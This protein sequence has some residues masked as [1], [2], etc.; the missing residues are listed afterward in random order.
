MVI[1]MLGILKAG[2]AYLPLDTNYPQ[3]R[4]A[5]ILRDSGASLALTWGEATPAFQE[6]GISLVRLDADWEAIAGQ[7]KNPPESGAKSENLIYTMYTSGSSGKPKGVGIIHSNVSR[8]IRNTNYVCITPDDVFLQLAPVTFDAA[9]F[10]IWGALLNGARLVLYPPDQMVDLVKLKKVI[11]EA[12]VSILWLTAGLFH[13]IVDEDLLLLAPIKQLLAG[14]DV[15]SAPHV[16]RVLERISGCRVINGY[17][18]T[19]C[20][21]FSVCHKVSDSRSV[22]MIVP[23]GRPVSN[24]LVYVLDSELELVPVGVAGE[25][26]IGGAGLA[27]G[28]FHHPELTAESFIPNP[29]DVCGSRLYRTGDLVRYSEDGDLEFVGR[30]DYQVKVGGYRIELEEIETALVSDPSVRQAAVVALA[31]S[32]GDKRLVA[33]V[34]GE[35]EATPHVKRLREHL[36]R[37]LPN[38]MIPSAFVVLKALPLTLNGKVDRKALPAPE[39]HSDQVTAQ[40]PIEKTVAEIWAQVLGTSEIGM[41]DDFFDLGGTSL[42]LISVVMK[43]SERFALPLDTSIVTQGA[44]V[45]AL[46]QAVREKQR[47]AE[48]GQ[49]G[50][51]TLIEKTVAEIWAQ[52]LGTSEI[53]MQDDFFDLGGT[54]LGLI[55]VVMK[56][57]ERFALPLDTSI[58]TQGATVSAL[59]QAVKGRSWVMPA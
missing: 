42:G 31:D 25:L 36:K 8:L 20:A 41:Q 44:T 50:A 28:Y 59:A 58:V 4:L 3:G 6:L 32:T 15:V 38:Y 47:G 13:R 51:N 22:E 2:G 9:T 37:G 53:G 29:F 19:E 7:P 48:A 24:T 34:V 40:T 11:Q 33:Y 49:Q 43:M 18:P 17:G 39:W 26:Y 55:S 52:V 27:R 5:Y 35:R 23:I 54:S 45:S 12:G 14:G 10:E 46:A 21:T 56:M 16:K 57:S 1:G 30:I